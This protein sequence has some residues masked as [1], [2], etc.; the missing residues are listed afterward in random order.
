MSTSVTTATTIN[1][2]DSLVVS[3]FAAVHACVQYTLL[4][5]SHII[6]F[7]N[8]FLYYCLTVLTS[9]ILQVME[10]EFAFGPSTW[11]YIIN[12]ISLTSFALT[13]LSPIISPLLCPIL[14]PKYT[15]LGDQTPHGN[16]M[17]SS[18]IHAIVTTIL[19][20]YIFAF[21]V[22]GTNRLF[23]QSPLGFA[24]M[25]ISLGYF[26]AD[27]LVCLWYPKLR[28]D[29]GSM[30]H[31]LAGIIGILL[32]LSHHGKLMFF[33]VYRQTA[34]LSTPFVNLFWFLHTYKL[35]ESWW[36]MFASIGMLITFFL[37][38]IIVMPWHWY[39]VVSMIFSPASSV[40][41]FMPL[42]YKIW[43]CI[44]Y[45]AFDAVNVYWLNKMIKGAMKLYKKVK[46]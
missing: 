19:A 17:L 20:A 15:T 26:V 46:V 14:S 8:T 3:K 11:P 42:G 45:L 28:N 4:R 12:A 31:H 43:I 16:T 40:D 18:T 24:V 30:I 37:T 29:I 23:S 44:N 34:E 13:L 21:G 41:N 1:H 5:I 2:H 33:I 10:E 38:R 25:Q 39:E 6:V 36:Y 22:M 9:Y 7:Y 35:K 27:F 32:S